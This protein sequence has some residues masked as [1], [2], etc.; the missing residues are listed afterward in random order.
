[1]TPHQFRHTVTRT[2]CYSLSKLKQCD[3]II[4]KNGLIIKQIDRFGNEVT[5]EHPAIKVKVKYMNVYKSL[6]TQLGMSPSSRAQLAGM[7]LKAKEDEEDPLL[8]LLKSH[9]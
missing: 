4:N 7:Q 9:T 3:D 8:Q 5:K 6:S 2:N 1:V